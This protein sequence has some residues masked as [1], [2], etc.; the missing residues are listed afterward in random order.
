MGAR[1]HD[2]RCHQ[3]VVPR[4]PTCTPADTAVQAI[5][6]LPEPAAGIVGRYLARV[7]DAAPGLIRGFYIVGS[8]ALDGSRVR[9]SDIDFVAT[10]A[11]TPSPKALSALRRVHRRCYAEGAVRAVVS[12]SWPLVCNG[13]SPCVVR[14]R[15]ASPSTATRPSCAPGRPRASCRTGN[16]GRMPSPAM[17]RRHGRRGSVSFRRAA[18][19][20]RACSAP[21]ACTPPSP[22]AR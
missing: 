9:R 2:A 21:P 18:W 15:A 11:G 16:R 8:I 7:D 5:G 13:A 17:G 3:L 12:R 4:Q 1:H 14:R 20:R 6:V 22:R 10:L 19:P